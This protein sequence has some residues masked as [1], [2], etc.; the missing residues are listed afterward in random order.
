[1]KTFTGEVMV[2]GPTGHPL[3][4]TIEIPGLGMLIVENSPTVLK[5]WIQ[6]RKNGRLTGCCH[7]RILSS[8]E[9]PIAFPSTRRVE[10]E[11]EIGYIE[12]DLQT[13][14]THG[15]VIS[16]VNQW[17][18][19][20]LDSAYQ[21]KAN[22]LPIMRRIRPGVW[23]FERRSVE[24]AQ[25]HATVWYTPVGHPVRVRIWEGKVANTSEEV[26]PPVAGELND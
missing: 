25:V 9:T 4:G 11:L 3:T 8:Q 1:M 15:D 7:S 17:I 10:L 20:F 5:C 21:A 16:E 22:P 26:Q 19:K 14:D 2:T 23:E 24:G 12:K 18:W 6:T 13:T